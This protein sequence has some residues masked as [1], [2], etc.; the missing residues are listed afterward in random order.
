ML[1]WGRRKAPKL[2]VMQSD[3]QMVANARSF[4]AQDFWGEMLIK[5]AEMRDGALGRL[6]QQA[7]TTEDDIRNLEHWRAVEE[8]TTQLENYPISVIEQ[9]NRNV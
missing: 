5:M 7:I 9:E 8:I 3:A 2:S 1:N 4:V 6:R